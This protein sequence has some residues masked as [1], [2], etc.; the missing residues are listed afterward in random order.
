M[1][2]HIARETGE[3][4]TWKSGRRDMLNAGM[5]VSKFAQ[6]QLVPTWYTVT[7]ANNAGVAANRL[8]R[9]RHFVKDFS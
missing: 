1:E 7:T 3:S 6:L 8:L 4:L 5:D 2:G 9:V